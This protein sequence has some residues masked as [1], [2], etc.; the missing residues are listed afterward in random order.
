MNSQVNR[1][2][3]EQGGGRTDQGRYPRKGH[4]NCSLR[5]ALG[6]MGSEVLTE[7]FSSSRGAADRKADGTDQGKNRQNRKDNQIGDA[8]QSCIAAHAFQ[9]VAG[10]EMRV[11]VI[12]AWE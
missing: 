2:L 6:V 10:T 5:T 4:R 1:A 7:T 12:G 11:R 9:Y 3:I 8:A